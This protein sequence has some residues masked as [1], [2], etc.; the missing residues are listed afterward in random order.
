[1]KSPRFVTPL[2]TPAKVLVLLTSNIPKAGASFMKLKSPVK[3]S[4]TPV[5][6]VEWS[7]RAS[8]CIIEMGIKTLGQIAACSGLE[9]LGRRN[10]GVNVLREMAQVCVSHN[11]SPNFVKDCVLRL[12]LSPVPDGFKRL[13]G[14]Y[15]SLERWMLEMAIAQLGEV[16]WHV[17]QELDGMV[18]YRSNSGWKD[19]EEEL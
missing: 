17:A 4:D 14:P 8:N 13:A 5:T 9:L 12:D 7:K 11:I 19:V 3:I 6:A 18:L 1:M 15:T 10:V 16:P 2:T